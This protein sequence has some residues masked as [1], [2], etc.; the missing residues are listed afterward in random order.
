MTYMFAIQLLNNKFHELPPSGGHHSLLFDQGFQKIA[1]RDW[2]ERHLIL[3]IDE[4]VPSHVV[5]RL[6]VE[7]QDFPETLLFC[8]AISFQIHVPIRNDLAA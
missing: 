4:I 1:G 3:G 7:Y 5:I 2:L 8:D 6:N